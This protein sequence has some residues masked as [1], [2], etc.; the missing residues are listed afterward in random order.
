MLREA[1]LSK[2]FLNISGNKL[3]SF[4]KGCYKFKKNM[5]MA[6]LRNNHY[7][8]IHFSKLSIE[9][10]RVGGIVVMR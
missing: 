7:I 2:I 4:K 1:N 10:E 8:I 9:P 5:S 3:Y 6:G